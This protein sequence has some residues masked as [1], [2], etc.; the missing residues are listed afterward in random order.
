MSRP[1]LKADL[2]TIDDQA[3]FA[4]LSGLALQQAAGERLVPLPDADRGII[5]EPAK[6]P[7]DRGEGGLLRGDLVRDLAQVD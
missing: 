6:A 3:D 1:V 2:A 7:E 4:Q 5:H